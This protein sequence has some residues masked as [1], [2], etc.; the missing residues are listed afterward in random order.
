[1]GLS[2]KSPHGERRSQQ[3]EQRNRGVNQGAP[4]LH[5]DAL[6]VVRCHGGLSLSR[7]EM[8]KRKLPSPHEIERRQRQRDEAVV[9]GAWGDMHDAKCVSGLG[10]STIA[11]L[12]R[13]EKIR[14]SKVGKRRLINIP[15]LLGYI[16]AH[17]VGPAA[18]TKEPEQLPA[19]E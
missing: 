5:I 7:P 4:S 17:A 14:S 16:E 10:R 9:A 11:D 15:S 1:M 19:A 6:F 2:G 8:R 18:P 13:R 3:G 12:I